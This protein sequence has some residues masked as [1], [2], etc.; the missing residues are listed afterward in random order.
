MD[1]DYSYGRVSGFEDSQDIAEYGY[2][3]GRPAELETFPT[4]RPSPSFLGPRRA[5]QRY[6][7]GSSSTL[8]YSAYTPEYSGSQI[9]LQDISNDRQRLLNREPSSSQT[10]DSVHQH[11][12]EEITPTR[13]GPGV[14]TDQLLVDRSLRG[15]ALL[16]SLFAVA[17]L[18]VICWHAKAFASKMNKYSSS[19]GGFSQ[20]CK[21]V[22]RTNTA[23][24]LLINAA[25]TMVLGMS[26]TYQQLVTSLRI[27]DLKHVLAKFG[28]S[29]VGTNSPMNMNKKSEGKWGSWA[30][31][32]LLVFTSIPVHFLAN[33]LIGPSYTLTPPETV[34]YNEVSATH[35]VAY[36]QSDET[37]VCWSAFRTG[38]AHL[39]RSPELL[40][41]DQWSTRNTLE[42]GLIYA[43]ITVHYTKKYCS[44]PEK[45]K[46]DVVA[47]VSPTYLSQLCGR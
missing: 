17:V 11:P 41:I 20:D 3:A 28:D 18:V 9:E 19:V 14:W 26:N 31:W 42:T 27:E 44:S 16:M 43:E 7:S 46:I 37:F 36:S 21:T 38:T 13:V 1:R 23:L 30:A 32:L 34:K 15:M 4:Y 5:D 35:L 2:A 39:P 25:A 24:L 45:V 12:A 10:E 40:E 29:R 8:N 33:S 47:R 6:S 22:T